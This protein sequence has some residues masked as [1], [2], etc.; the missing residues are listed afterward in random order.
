MNY[1]DI[2]RNAKRKGEANADSRY[3]ALLLG[4]TIL[5]AGLVVYGIIGE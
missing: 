3:N 5:F 2:E 4:L 1:P